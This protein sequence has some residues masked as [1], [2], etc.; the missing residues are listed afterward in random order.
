MRVEE[1]R[2]WHAYFLRNAQAFAP[3][4]KKLAMKRVYEIESVIAKKSDIP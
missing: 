1:L 4:I 2:T 3:K